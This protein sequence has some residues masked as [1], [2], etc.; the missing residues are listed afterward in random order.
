M[1]IQPTKYKIFLGPL[2]TPNRV[3]VYILTEK[4]L[5]FCIYGSQNTHFLKKRKAAPLRPPQM[6][7]FL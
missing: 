1:H 4:G 2:V 6:I 5:K 7:I 3:Y